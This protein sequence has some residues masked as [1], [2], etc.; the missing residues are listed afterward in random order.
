MN[1]DPTPP[2][3]AL[4][5]LAWFCPDKLYEGI[6]GDL[7]ESFRDDA[8]TSGEKIARRRFVVNVFRFFRP[9]IILRNK[10]SIELISLIMLTNYLTIAYRNLLKSKSFSAINIFGLGIGLAACLLI[11][12]F[13]S[14]ELSFDKFN[15]KLDRTYR[16]TNDRFK[17]GK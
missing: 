2:K 12:Q 4:R 9:S 8:K 13:V 5:F 15:E 7:L 17:N 1:H 11:F 6:E 16:I 10:F 3:Y 14:F